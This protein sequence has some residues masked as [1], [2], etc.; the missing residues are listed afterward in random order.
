LFR[1]N[2]PSSL[3][4]TR[5]NYV[6]DIN[7]TFGLIRLDDDSTFTTIDENVIAR[8]NMLFEIKGPCAIRNNIC[9]DIKDLIIKR[10]FNAE[11]VFD[12]NVFIG[13]DA[14]R[15]Q[16]KRQ[17]KIETFWTSISR[18]HNSVL[19]VPPPLPAVSLG[20]DLASVEQRGQAQVGLLYTDP[21]LDRDAMKQKIYR[22]KPGSPCEK[23][24]IKPLDLSAVG[25]TVKDPPTVS[26][27]R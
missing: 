18:C 6:H 9:I 19:F 12:H 13:T 7:N 14:K 20:Q 23:L 1:Q 22:F 25:S 26:S 2:Q 24:G 5:T 8:G 11:I 15:T 16:Y 4:A 17:N 3:S 21:L 10:W 27:D